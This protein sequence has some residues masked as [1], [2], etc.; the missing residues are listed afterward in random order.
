MITYLTASESARI[1]ERVFATLI[2]DLNHEPIE[3][4]VAWESSNSFSDRGVTSNRT[5]NNRKRD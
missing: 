4:V 2:Y 5:R 1:V 3:K